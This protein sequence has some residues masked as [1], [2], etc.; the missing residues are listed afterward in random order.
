M[1]ATITPMRIDLHGISEAAHG[2]LRVKSKNSPIGAL[3]RK[4]VDAGMCDMLPVEVY[5][6]DVLCF[7]AAPLSYWSWWTTTESDNA[8][9]PLRRVRYVP[10]PAGLNEVAE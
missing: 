7:R 5:R 10:R 3:A 2:D 1:S 6:G 4:L 9:T 8:T